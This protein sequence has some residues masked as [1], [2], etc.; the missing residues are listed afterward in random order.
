[1][2][3]KN[4]LIHLFKFKFF[5]L[6]YKFIIIYLINIKYNNISYIIHIDVYVIHY[7]TNFR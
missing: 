1:M 2:V 6:K 3:K 5:S 7:S 4:S